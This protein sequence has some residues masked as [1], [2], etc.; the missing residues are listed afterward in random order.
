MAITRVWSAAVVLLVVAQ[1]SGE[2][3]ATTASSPPAPPPQQQARSEKGALTGDIER[4]RYIVERVAMCAE[5]HS[6]R[7]ED[8]NF[9]PE[10]RFMGAPIPVKPPW[11]NNWAIQ[12]PRNRGLPGYTEELAVRLLTQGAIGRNSQRLRPP[13]PRFRMTRQDA[14]DVV[15]YLKSLE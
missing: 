8:G 10:Q 7:D 14:T 5:C 9:I 3:D 6:P 4:G 13:M 1:V 12:A 11:P 15:A 2:R